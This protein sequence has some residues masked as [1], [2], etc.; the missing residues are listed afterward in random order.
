M[1][2]QEGD[3]IGGGSVFD[4]EIYVTSD[5]GQNWSLV[6][7]AGLDNALAGEWGLNTWYEAATNTLWFGTSKGRSF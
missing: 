6:S 5:G 2:L 1:E 3:P 7:G 4:F